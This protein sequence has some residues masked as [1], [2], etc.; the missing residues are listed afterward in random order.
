M[1]MNRRTWAVGS[2]AAILA[3]A[4][5]LPAGVVAKGRP[6]TESSNNLSAPTYMVGGAAFTGVACGAGE[7]STL[8]YPSGTPRSDY[9]AT[10]DWWVQRIHKWQAQC[11][12]LTSA[13][14]AAA[15]GDNLGG[16]A[17]LRSG[18]PI[19][20]EL[21]LIGFNTSDLK[22]FPTVKLEPSKLDRE[23][24]YGTAAVMG[25][26]GWTAIAD[27]TE[28]LRVFDGQATFSIQR[29][30]DGTYVVNPGTVA[31]G[32]INAAGRVVYGYQ[33]KVMVK[34]QYTITYHLPNVN[35][36]GTDIGSV[37]ADGH[38]VSLTITII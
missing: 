23:S 24:A 9:E 13:S 22:G 8:V 28:A 27:T 35:L 30:A 36:T 18:K 12:S 25:D 10:G 38:D 20:V 37:S 5:V 17:K 34:G 15:W 16:D 7:A 1:E 19:R 6:A 4:L 32:E 33:L 11:A 21:G 2:L 26:A 31:K 14:A 29:V 3:L